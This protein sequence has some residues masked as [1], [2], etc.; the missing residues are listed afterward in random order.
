ME[1]LTITLRR[2]D[3]GTLSY[4]LDNNGIITCDDSPDFIR[5]VAH[6]ADYFAIISGA[7]QTFDDSKTER[8]TVEV[9]A[10]VAYCNDPRVEI[11]DYDNQ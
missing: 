7:H 5:S 8:I 6:E 11:I 3:D 10:G 9:R 4:E 1:K 2:D